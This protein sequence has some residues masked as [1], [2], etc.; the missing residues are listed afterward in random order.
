MIYLSGGFWILRE[1]NLSY[2]VKT[3]IN[4]KENKNVYFFYIYAIPFEPYLEQITW[5]L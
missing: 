1:K 5:E 2:N 3:G 4:G